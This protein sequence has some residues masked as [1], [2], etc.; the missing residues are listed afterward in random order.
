M[1]CTKNDELRSGIDDLNGR[2]DMLLASTEQL[3]DDLS[4]ANG[5]IN[6]TIT[7]VGYSVND[8]GDYTVE[9]SDGK[10]MTIYKGVMESETTISVGEDGWVYTVD[11]TEYPMLGP[12]NQPAPVSGA[13]PQVRVTDNGRWEYSFDGETWQGGFGTALPSAGS[14]FDD[15]Y[16]SGDGDALVFVWH[17]GDT[18]YEK[19]VKLFGGL[20]LTIDFGD[21]TTDPVVFSVNETKTFPVV[22]TNVADIVVETVSWGVK[23]TDESISIT[24][25]SQAD[26]ENIIIKIFSEAGYCIPVIIPVIAE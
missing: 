23:I 16:A 20:D 2:L 4:A 6:G 19:E 3:N 7:I 13:T 25:P 8:F 12:D 18:V 9:F 10:S 22:Q 26:T 5:I 11:G 21:E 24:A 14:I 17:S 15:V 1:S